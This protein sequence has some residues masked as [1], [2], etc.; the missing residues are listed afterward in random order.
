MEKPKVAKWRR[1]LAVVTTSLGFLF[2]STAYFMYLR[3]VSDP[4]NM[5]VQERILHA[6]TLGLLWSTSFYG[7]ILLLVA[8][9]LG[10]G[11]GRWMGLIVNAA[12]F[13]CALMI[14]GAMCG[15]FGCS[16]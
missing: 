11:W 14:V 9:L 15:P 13:T 1:R 2:L 4:S 10:L 6:R 12:A 7:S 3:Y 5:H 16:P 8:S